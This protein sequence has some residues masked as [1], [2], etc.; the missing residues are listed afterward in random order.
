[1]RALHSILNRAAAVEVDQVVMDRPAVLQAQISLVHME[2][3][4]EEAAAT[5]TIIAEA[6]E[7]EAM[8][9][10]PRSHGLPLL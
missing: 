5:T 1:M 2:A 10:S 6:A 7:L 8:D 9:R 3:V 4:A